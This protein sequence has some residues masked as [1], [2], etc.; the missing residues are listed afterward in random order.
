MK[1]PV[2]GIKTSVQTHSDKQKNEIASSIS[3]LP[4]I[5]S[6]PFYSFYVQRYHAQQRGVRLA[7]TNYETAEARC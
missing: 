1:N 7:A 2:A 3:F 5:F 6:S 4:F